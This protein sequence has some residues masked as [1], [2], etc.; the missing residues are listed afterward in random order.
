ML[1]AITLPTVISPPLVFRRLRHAARRAAAERQCEAV[2]QAAGVARHRY[3]ERGA[4]S[5]A[6]IVFAAAFHAVAD[7]TLITADCLAI[8]A[9][10]AAMIVF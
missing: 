8:A 3:A 1:F 6:A 10:Y 2:W 7:A 9:A 4:G 5:A